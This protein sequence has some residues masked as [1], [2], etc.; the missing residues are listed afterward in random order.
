[1]LLPEAQKALPKKYRQLHSLQLA[2]SMFCMYGT[3]EGP[4]PC[5]QQAQKWTSFHLPT[6]TTMY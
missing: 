3:D 2:R 4:V 5:A 1:M 6:Q